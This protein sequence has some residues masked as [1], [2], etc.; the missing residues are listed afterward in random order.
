MSANSHLPRAAVLEFFKGAPRYTLELE[1][2]TPSNNQL[3]RM[4]F[5]AYQ[6]LRRQWRMK[7]LVALKGARPSASAAIP[8]AGLA[9]TRY[10]AGTLD[11]DNAYGGLKPLLDCLVLP[12]QRNPDGLGLIVDDSPRCMPLAPLMFQEPARRGLPRMQIL[13]WD[14]NA[15]SS[16]AA[17]PSPMTLSSALQS[18]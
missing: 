16:P 11:W 4:H 2:A 7:V 9:V 12:T 3:K 6:R 18:A 17:V 5:F 8:S 14:L 10:C 13:I 1:G 15:N